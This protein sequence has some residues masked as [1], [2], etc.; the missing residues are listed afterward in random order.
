MQILS[1][2]IVFGVAVSMSWFV[3]TDAIA[4][5]VI[6]VV[7]IKGAIVEAPPCII[8]NGNIIDVNFGDRIGVNTV[9]GS[10]YRLRLNYQVRCDMAQPSGASLTLML[11]GKP[12]L[13]DVDD[14]SILTNKDGL[15]IKV[16]QGS[17][18]MTLGKRFKVEMN[19]LPVLEAVPIKDSNV[20][21][22][23]GTFD[24]GATLLAEYY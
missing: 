19:K 22:T 23:A 4:V 21:L 3:S 13:F 14:A 2:N 8:S 20:T 24:V 10:N 11:I 1:R 12:A 5:N 18:P 16:Y 17:Q 6:D 9:D 7:L 15:A